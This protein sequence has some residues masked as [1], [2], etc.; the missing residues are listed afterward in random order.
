MN[1]LEIRGLTKEYPGFRLDGLDLTLPQGCILGLIGENGAGKSTA[2]K[3]I[4]GMLKRS[5]GT[6]SVYGQDPSVAPAALR[7]DIGVV[8]D[9][10][11]IPACLTVQ[12]VGKVM[13]G[14]FRQWEP[15]TF[16]RLIHQLGLPEK[17]M[18]GEFS[19]G[20][21]MKLGIAIALSHK[22]RLL[23]LDE[24]TGGLD[25]VAR[26]QVVGLLHEF[27]RDPSH[28]VLISSHIVSDLEKLCDYIAF[29]HGG[30][31]LFC[32]EKDALLEKYGIV[33]CTHE[34]L[35]D[36]PKSAVVSLRANQ[37][38]IQALVER[39]AVSS[40]FAPEKPTMEDIILFMVKG[41]KPA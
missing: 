40:V 16:A 8:M 37:Y 3:L 27:T 14:V 41:E 4:L 23:L 34:Q 22:A 21:K 35:A 30:E 28:A 29:L 39:S 6:V 1:A 13:T 10:A 33:A 26:E 24:P 2:I 9:E 5:G 20:M 12:Q 32:Q 31:L 17:K 19:K 25:P 36:L 15:D 11:G 18:F 7:E 38:G